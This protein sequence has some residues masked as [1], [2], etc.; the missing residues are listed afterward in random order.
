[1][2]TQAEQRGGRILGRSGAFSHH[3]TLQGGD[4]AAA[5]TAATA[6]GGAAAAASA[7][8]AADNKAPPRDLPD[9]RGQGKHTA[10]VSLCIYPSSH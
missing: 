4:A 1:M 10:R 2:L 6:G 8:R 9:E 7:A 3:R 5:A